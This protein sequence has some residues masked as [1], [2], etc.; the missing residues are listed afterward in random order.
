MWLSKRKLA[1]NEEEIELAESNNVNQSFIR[2][3]KSTFPELN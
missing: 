2:K 1:G 3:K